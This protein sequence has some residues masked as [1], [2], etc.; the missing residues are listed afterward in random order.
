MPITLMTARSADHLQNR[1][2]MM[3]K[4]GCTTSI[5]SYMFA[6]ALSFFINAKN[7]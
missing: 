5:P 2:F 3:P 6:H 1:R 7:T 4:L